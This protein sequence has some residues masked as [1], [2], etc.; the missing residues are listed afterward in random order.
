MA[1]SDFQL[2]PVVKKFNLEINEE[3]DLFADTPERECS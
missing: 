1:Y 3:I 2:P